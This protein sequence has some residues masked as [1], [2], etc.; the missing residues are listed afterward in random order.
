[1]AKVLIVEDDLIIADGT[2]EFLA[3]CGYEVCGSART[4]D[5]AVELGRRHRPDLVILDLRLADGGFGTE[6]AARLTRL[7]RVGILYATGNISQFEL[8]TAD[9]DASIVKPYSRADLLRSLEIVAEIVTT[10]RA[11]P[12]F[13]SGFHM[14]PL[15]LSADPTLLAS[16]NE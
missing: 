13:P 14:L 16:R 2:E 15:A 8:D 3:G 10:G 4:V 6:V 1:M 7:G 9:G 11:S 5:D 12:P